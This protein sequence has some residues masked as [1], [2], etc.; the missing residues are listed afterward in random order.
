M[1]G[2]I[3]TI[4]KWKGELR[5]NNGIDKISFGGIPDKTLAKIKSIV[6]PDS[7]EEI[8]A[9][10]FRP[11]EDTLEKVILPKGLKR[12]KKESFRGFPKLKEVILPPSIEFIGDKAF[13]G[14]RSLTHVVIPKPS[15]S[16]QI[17]DKAFADCVNLLYVELEEGFI[18]KTFLGDRVF[19][20]TAYLDELRKKDPLV[21]IQGEIIDGKRCRGDLIIPAHVKGVDIGA[22]SFNLDLTSVTLPKSAYINSYA[23]EGCSSLKKV[24]LPED[25]R[26]LHES[27]FSGCTSLEEIVLPQN[28]EL[29]ISGH[30]FENTPW[31]KKRQKEG[32]PT[33][34][35]GWVID[36]STCKGEVHL[37]G[38]KG[39]AKYAFRLNHEITKVTIEEG[40]EL[41]SPMAFADCP[42]L[43]EVSLPSQMK[44]IG[45]S[46]FKNCFQLRMI[47]IPEGIEN[48]YM[49]TFFNCMSLT[50]ISLP[51]SLK[52]IHCEAFFNCKKLN[53]LEI[54]PKVKKDPKSF[55]K[56]EELSLRKI[57]T[58]TTKSH[59]KKLDSERG[60]YAS[61]EEEK[62]INRNDIAVAIIPE[63]V[64]VIEKSAFEGCR[65]LKK[66]V[67]PTTLER[68]E[69]NAFKSCPLLEYI[70]LPEQLKV[71]GESAF[72]GCYN[73]KNLVLPN[74]LEQIGS[75]AFNFCNIKN[76]NLPQSLKEIGD[77]CFLGCEELRFIHWPASVSIIKYKMFSGCRSLE[78]LEIPEG[79][80]SIESFSL[81]GCYKIKTLQLPS[82]INRIEENAFFDSGLMEITLP[83]GVE[84]IESYA[85]E[86]C[87]QLHSV[88]YPTSLKKI[89]AWAFKNCNKLQR[90]KKLKNVKI[91]RDA[92][93][94]SLLTAF[95]DL[96]RKC[97]YLIVIT[98]IG[99]FV[100]SVILSFFHP[101]LT[102][103]GLG[104][105]IFVATCLILLGLGYIILS[106]AFRG[107][108]H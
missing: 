37:S 4:N 56:D 96:N 95:L 30:V 57:I 68:I 70:V 8:K 36:G 22:F 2:E 107:A 25:L 23:F 69:E 33:I 64:K 90:P 35:N 89:E 9:Y 52:E 86:N 11:V 79:I 65:F 84:T 42:A 28:E 5:F 40:C 34:L 26:N 80:T 92:Y 97:N 105:V 49:D 104:I 88:G 98:A 94:R 3:Y 17:C 72:D 10:D 15:T 67:L 91:H 108:H 13:H 38:I 58:A 87:E 54:A 100:L 32:E 45:Y 60:M 6:L 16:L 62:Y 63:G 66:V 20:N 102:A 53:P 82:T 14:C 73:L 41:I 61:I 27:T 81:K 24:V 19:E 50:D 83:E 74:H 99:W 51:N 1:K 78:H 101:I 47:N 44:E 93:K 21:I 59:S 55:S 71:I 46:A 106:I 76:I 43:K 85:F 75:D 7:L 77:S 48:I 29:T 39:I 31:L 18:E 12:I 103:I